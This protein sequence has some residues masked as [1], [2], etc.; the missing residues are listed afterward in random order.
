MTCNVGPRE[1]IIRLASGMALGA[2]AAGK[3]MSTWKRIGLGAVAVAQIVTATTRYCP[4]NQL[5]GIDNCP[6]QLNNSLP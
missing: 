3:P 5:F 4:V 2:V 6:E 1:R